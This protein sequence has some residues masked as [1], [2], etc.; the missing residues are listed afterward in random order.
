MAEISVI[1]PSYNH[2]AYIG[3]AVRSVLSQSMADLELIVVDDGSQDNSLEVLAGFSDAR[4]RID[5]QVNQGA[6]AAINRGL[7][8]ATGDYLA[9]L[10]SD[11]AYHPQRLEKLVALLKNNPAIG[12]AGSYIQLIDQQ[13][14]SLGIKHGYRDCEP[15]A[16]ENPGRSFRAGDDLKA[17]LLTE[18][19]FATSSNFVFPIR[20]FEQ[21]GEFRPLRFTHDWDYAL[22]LANLAELAL[23][24]EPLM[25]YRV[26]ASNTIRQDRAT[27]LFEICWIMAVHLP[28]YVLGAPRS[29]DPGA[30][31]ASPG[32]SL[33]KRVE[34]LLH[35]IY[36]GQCDRL[37]E[38]MLLQN[39]H[40]SLDQALQ[41]LD[42]SDPIRAVYLDYTRRVV[43]KE[44]SVPWPMQSSW[45][46]R[47]KFYL[48][49]FFR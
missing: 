19:Y 2:A 40:T 4:L 11:D 24:P 32:E 46:Q 14:K 9:I 39:L 1:I 15:W 26:H 48:R 47:V 3:E 49:K 43:Q 42:E 35:S 36:T 45:L 7:R 38:V 33:E 16:L 18:N 10:N 31:P 20:W 27:M 34:G 6:H 5:R 17:A 28:P 37:L 29:S 25:L 21:V 30:L 41:L 13:G 22:R 23:V 44:E 12:L 8:Q